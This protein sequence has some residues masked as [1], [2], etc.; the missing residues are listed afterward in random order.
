MTV[1][2]DRTTQLENP[3]GGRVSNDQLCKTLF[4]QF[5]VVVVVV[6]VVM[7]PHS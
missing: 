2:W 4:Q 7:P 5:V 3:P 1:F 6:V